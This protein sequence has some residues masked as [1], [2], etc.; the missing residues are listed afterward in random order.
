M[1]EP[2]F[3]FFAEVWAAYKSENFATFFKLMRSA[4]LLQACLMRPYVSELRLRALAK[5]A[6]AH[7]PTSTTIIPFPLE[8]LQRLLLFEDSDDA[9]KFCEHCQVQVL[10]T[11]IGPQIQLAK[12]EISSLLP[13]DK[14]GHAIQ[15]VRKYG[16]KYGSCFEV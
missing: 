10:D 8:D 4:N 14:N 7:C 5:I 2:E 9:R 11:S 3:L 16:S 12:Q 6:Y 13:L 1:E 15:P